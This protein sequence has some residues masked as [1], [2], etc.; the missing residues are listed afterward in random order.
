MIYRRVIERRQYP[1]GGT[2]NSYALKTTYSIPAIADP[3]VVAMNQINSAGVT[4]ASEK[5]YF[6]R[7]VARRYKHV[8]E[9]FDTPRYK[10]D[11]TLQTRYDVELKNAINRSNNRTGQ[12]QVWTITG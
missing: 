5:H 8:L 12:A 6:Y 3:T 2:L 10:P 9:D 11:G 4:L 7:G 1:D